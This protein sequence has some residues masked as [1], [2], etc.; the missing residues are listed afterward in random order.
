MAV[1]N[2]FATATSA[3]PLSQLDANFSYFT[4]QITVTSAV[5]VS[6]SGTF[7]VTG[8]T[9]LSSA[10]TYG[11]V[12]L[13][14][15]VTGTGSMVL[16]TSPTLT[17]PN[18]G[19]AT[20]TSLNIGSGALTAGAITASGQIT[21][22]VV[23]GKIFESASTTTGNMYFN[24]ENS[25]GRT[26]YGIE[27]SAGGSLITGSG[28]Y[29]TFISTVGVTGNLVLGTNVTAR[30]TITNAGAVST[31]GGALTA[32]ATGVTTL[33]A[34][35]VSTLVGNVGVGAAP[36]NLYVAS[37][38]KAIDMPGM[39]ILSLSGGTGNSYF[40][41]N[42]YFDLAGAPLYRATA[43]AGQLA[44]EGNVLTFKT[45]PSGTAGTGV[46]FTSRLSVDVNG[47]NGV[48]GAT[49]P[50]AASVTTLTAT[51]ATG[52][53]VITFTNAA[54]NNKTG[55]LYSDA[56]YV[57]LFTS[58]NAAGGANGVYADVTNATVKIQVAASGAVATFTS[59]GI[60]GVL[61]ATT[62]AAA[63][64][65]TLLATGQI[66]TTGAYT[67]DR[68]NQITMSMSAPT[69]QLIVHGPDNSTNP[70]WNLYLVRANG[71]NV[72]TPIQVSNAGA[73]SMANGAAV[74]GTLS[75]TGV[76]T[77]S[78]YG[79]GTA[80]FNGSG[81]ISSVSD[82]TWKIK[83]GAPVDTDAMLNKLEPGYWHYNDEKKETFGTDRQLG[84]YAQNVH[85]SI[86]PEAAPEPEE[87][88]P[89]GY[90][91][92]SVLAVTVLSL[93]KALATIE[94]LRSRVALLEAK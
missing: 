57:G 3:I 35:G 92:R 70:A 37:S 44:L 26:L 16:A 36:V 63:S 33:T 43:A 27:S 68:A 76:V 60:N 62:P 88:K 87:G 65:T 85:A 69:G 40:S 4:N 49:T 34:S 52:G 80:T 2:I 8:A 24:F 6:I 72:L 1:P 25:G 83:D 74:T 32:G 46:S 13:A 19:A 94:S 75:A 55:F 73:V 30:V 21:S 66:S 64:V 10:L 15:A 86:G 20:G 47:M 81:V 22:T 50:A 53:D 82:E 39:S 91:D 71:T 61:G 59:G 11:G 54:A 45:A 51:K 48:L 79:V 23:G 84:F 42:S 41:I 56:Q 31:N 9:T 29:D 28:A 93:Q 17:T 67:T 77:F 14:N 89:W 58:A 7:G 78:N 18:I 5:G 12:T 38:A 90:Y